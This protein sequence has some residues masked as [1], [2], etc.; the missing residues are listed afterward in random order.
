MSYFVLVNRIN[1][2]KRTSVGEMRNIRWRW[3][4]VTYGI[5]QLG[6]LVCYPW[7]RRHLL[8]ATS[9]QTHTQQMVE[10]KEKV[11]QKRPASVHS[12][13]Y[14]S[15]KCVKQFSQISR[16]IWKNTIADPEEHDNLSYL[17]KNVSSQQS[18]GFWCETHFPLIK[19]RWTT[20][21]WQFSSC[22]LCRH[23]ETFEL[24]WWLVDDYGSAFQA[25]QLFARLTVKQNWKTFSNYDPVWQLV[26]I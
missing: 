25:F 3:I 18:V 4:R 20:R 14:C 22:L 13:Q 16:L 21:L 19:G 15:T 2:R 17:M 11:E 10:I 1:G 12:T 24:P 8:L 7:C 9:P 5:S 26:H 23:E 6:R